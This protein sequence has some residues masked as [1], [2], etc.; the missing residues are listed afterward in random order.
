MF[1]GGINSSVIPALE[2]ISPRVCHLKIKAPIPDSFFPYKNASGELIQTPLQLSSQK[3][4][5]ILDFSQFC[6][7]KEVKICQAEIDNLKALKI[8][9]EEGQAIYRWEYGESLVP[10]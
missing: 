6:E 9:V 5:V 3:T 10:H 8:F 2:D 1:V 7:E 4:F